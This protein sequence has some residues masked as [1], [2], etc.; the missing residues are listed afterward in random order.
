MN[1]P[2]R[3]GFGKLKGNRHGAKATDGAHQ[4]GAQPPMMG[5]GAKY[6]MPMG[7]SMGMANDRNCK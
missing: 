4:A 7:D 2:V 3:K 5:R 6:P 1:K